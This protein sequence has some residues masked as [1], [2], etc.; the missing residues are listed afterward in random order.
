MEQPTISIMIH[1]PVRTTRVVDLDDVETDPPTA[2]TGTLCVQLAHGGVVGAVEYFI[3]NAE[4]ARLTIHALLR[5][6]SDLASAAVRRGWSIAAPEVAAE[7]E[8]VAADA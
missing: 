7:P 8:A 6:G 3:S 2:K 1:G 4:D 5:A